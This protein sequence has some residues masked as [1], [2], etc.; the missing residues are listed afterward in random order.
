M[1]N[2]RIY[3]SDFYGISRSVIEEY[4][5][6]DI[7]LHNDIPLFIDPFL[8]FCSEEQQCQDMHADIITYLKYLRDL[9]VD[10]P[11]LSIHELKYLYCFPEVKQTYLGFCRNGNAGSGLGLGFARALHAGLKDIFR[12]FG[13]E[14]VTKGHHIEKVCL[15]RSGVGRDNISDFITNLIKPYLLEYTQAFSKKYLS[16]SQCKTFSVN[17]VRFDYS[18]GIWR[19]EKY[20][21]PYYNND[22]VLLTPASLLVRDDTWI[23]RSDMIHNFETFAASI[24]DPILRDRVNSYFASLLSKKAK[25]TEKETAAKATIQSF[26]SINRSL[27]SISGG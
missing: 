25:K 22:Y 12:N 8:I 21:L 23:N 11:N 17:K 20:Y 13:E 1:S 2:N 16:S 6:M 7:S 27:Y 15:L 24:P 26:S 10:N 18:F 14:T 5:A 19:D 4:G 9:S 3:F